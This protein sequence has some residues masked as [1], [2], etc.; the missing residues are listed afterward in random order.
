MLNIFKI[1][2]KAHK[3]IY[4]TLFKKSLLFDKN[5]IKKLDSLLRSRR[6]NSV[7]H[8][9]CLSR[10]KGSIIQVFTNNTQKLVAC[11][12]NKTLTNI[13]I[14]VNSLWRGFN[15][16][17][18]KKKLPRHKGSTIIKRNTITKESKYNWICILY[19]IPK[20]S[21]D[22]SLHMK[23]R[24]NT[25][26]APGIKTHPLNNSPEFI[27]KLNSRHFFNISIINN[28]IDIN[29]MGVCIPPKQ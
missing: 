29:I 19:I 23:G 25:C 1:L 18:L 8:N 20:I 28:N 11:P 14:H 2:D 3:Y 7:K 17:H 9:R 27:F 16:A 13:H 12:V 26:K 21:E 24:L 15:A 5:I 10:I 4:I 22:I 6:R